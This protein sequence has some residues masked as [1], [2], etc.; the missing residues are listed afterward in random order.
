MALARVEKLSFR[1][2]EAPGPALDGVSLEL[3]Q[4][5]VV[6]LLG[7][8]G[9]G[10]SSLLRALA[11]LV[12]HFH[13]GTFGGRV[14]VAG[15]DTRSTRPAE[16]AGDVATLFQDPEDQVVFTRVAAEVAFGL[17]NIG[18]PSAF[19]PLRAAGALDAVGAGHLA[20]RRVAELS[21]GELQRVCLASVLALE[22]GLL[23]LDEPTSQLDP[24]GAEEA[25]E[26]ARAAGAA[27]V[28]SEQRPDRV[29]DACDRVLFL[30]R[31]RIVLDAPQADALDWLA[32]NRPAWL[33]REAEP[34]RREPE[35]EP[36]CRLDAVSFGQPGAAR[37][38]G[39]GTRPPPG[40]WS[41]TGP[42]G[43][44]KTTLAK[45]A[46]GLL[47]GPHRRRSGW[48]CYRADPGRY[49]V[50][51]RV[52]TRSRWPSTA[53]SSRPQRVGARPGRLRGPSPA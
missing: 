3:E 22:P 33:P 41:L 15:R 50:R 10:K 38:R 17:E 8:S 48:A 40:R 14:E 39:G 29:L 20:E 37:P 1:Y 44:G 2:P 36:A 34:R 30:D 25:I 26:L 35:G 19:I 47:L 43:S 21:G 9:G 46:A 23:L 51:E 53:I 31:G 4:G 12:P 42:N 49:L 18:T 28:V 16:L 27:V 7:P 6:A 32:R 5:E 13:G 11:G 24:E 45:I 52:R